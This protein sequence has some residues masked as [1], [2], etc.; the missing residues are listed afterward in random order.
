MAAREQAAG[1]L[2]R[3]I[4]GASLS[5]V[6]PPVQEQ[7]SEAP[8]I[9]ELVYGSLRWHFLLSGL[10]RLLLEKPLRNKDRDVECLL[11]I[12]LYQLREMRIPAHAVVNET[13]RETRTM[14]KPWAKGLVNGVLRR[15]QRDREALEQQLDTAES[16]AH[17]QWLLQKLQ[18]AYPEPW[19][20]ICTANNQRP[21]MV[22][23]VNERRQTVDEYL[24]ELNREGV[25]AKRHPVA[26]QALV[27]DKACDVFSLPGFDEGRVSVQDAAAQLAAGLLD[28]GP[29]MR[30]LDACAAPGGKTAHILEQG[31]SSEVWA[32][33]KDAARIQSL[34]QTLSRLGLEARIVEADAGDVE[35]W[36]D[37]QPFDRILLD[38]P[39]SAT[40]VIRRH[41]DIRIHR[42]PADIDRLREEQQRLLR[43]LWPLLRP[44]GMLLYATCSILP[45]ENV[46]Q[47]TMFFD[48]RVNAREFAL[49]LE[50]G[51]KQS[52]GRQILP[53]EQG[54][55]G[56]F[57]AGIRKISD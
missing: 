38:A 1:V 44:G 31:E 7:S 16:M 43:A 33:E 6:M 28:L 30:I 3:V 45:E 32:L 20:D 21:P 48:D 24:Q 52:Y 50:Y 19:R 47:V 13:V 55:D 14:K 39:C 51:L 9:Q 8:L 4:D 42:R 10:I 12:G 29:G 37:G 2:A 41:P 57:Y 46:E 36:W 56:F 53:G 27:L 25:A 15:Y 17:P 34:T 23:R 35:A 5:R 18:D 11:R 26:P 54:M 49:P 40:G 22:L